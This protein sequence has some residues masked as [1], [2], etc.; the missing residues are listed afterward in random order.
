M[1]LSYHPY[2]AFIRENTYK[3]II[4]YFF[5]AFFLILGEF[6]N[7]RTPMKINYFGG[8][9]KN[10]IRVA[11]LSESGRKLERD[12]LFIIFRSSTARTE[13]LFAFLNVFLRIKSVWC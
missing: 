5:K 2:V 1:F 10:S 4:L 7:L 12:V 13:F 9:P 3:K 6:S 11:T 8:F